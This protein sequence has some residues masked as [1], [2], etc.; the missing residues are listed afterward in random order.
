MKH[1][2]KA[3]G[4][5]WDHYYLDL[6]KV[7]ATKSKDPST[8]CSAICV[9]QDN[10]TLSTGFNG[11]PRGV[12]EDIPERWE[13]PLKYDFVA[14]GER[15]AIDNAARVGISLRGAKMYLNYRPECCTECTKAIIQAGI[16]EVIGPP[17]PFPGKGKGTNYDLYGANFEMME[18]A[19]IMLTVIGDYPE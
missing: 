9:T 5:S 18:E 19:G 4:T 6:A 12:N 3:I 11:F 14:H 10:S 13:R 17:T 1:N 16:T 8:K 7:V 2:I 15:N